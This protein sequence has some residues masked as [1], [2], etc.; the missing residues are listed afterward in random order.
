M[1]TIQK[2]PRFQ[3]FEKQ[4]TEVLLGLLL[5]VMCS[6]GG[7]RLYS[8]AQGMTWQFD[9]YINLRGLT[10]AST[11]PGVLDFVFG[12]TAGPLGRPLSLLTFLANYADWDK[13]PWGVARLNLLFHC[14]NG[15]LAY[16]LARRLL[17]AKG[18]GPTCSTGVA[19]AAACLW[20]LM[21]VNAS[22]ILMPVQRMTQV[23]AF[24]TLFT[25]LGYAA[26]RSRYE[27]SPS[28]K[29]IGGLSA[30]VGLG[31]LLSVLAKENGAIGL[32]L[33]GL[34]EWAVFK[35]TPSN[36]PKYLIWKCWLAASIAAVPVALAYHLISEWQGIQSHF[37][38][39]RGYSQS[40]HIATQ[41]VISWE[42]IRQILVPR[43][44][45][46]GPYQDGHFVYDWGHWQVY[47]AL[48][49]WAA[50][51]TVA[52]AW[53]RCGV[54]RLRRVGRLMIFSGLWFLACHQ[55]ESTFIP[56]ELYFEHRN[57]VAAM[58]AAVLVAYALGSLMMGE[59]QKKAVAL[60]S[61]AAVLLF[62]GFSLQQLTSLWGQPWLASEM[63][64]KNHPN[65]LRATQ[66]L[67]SDN[68]AQGY[69]KAALSISDDYVAANRSAAMEILYFPEHCKDE[70]Q[71]ILRQR[72][73]K[74]MVMISELKQ[75]GAIPWGLAKMGE[76]IRKGNCAGIESDDYIEFLR[77]ILDQPAVKRNGP[78][79]HH[80]NYEMALT[81]L[82]NEDLSEYYRYARNAF[83]DFPSIS[84]AQQIALTLFAHGEFDAALSWVEE[85]LTKAPNMALRQSWQK[86]LASLRDALLQVKKSV[87]NE[88]V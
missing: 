3:K 30:W 70:S 65:S 88:P 24:F 18:E 86:Q 74:L 83:F 8:L 52:I 2:Y 76:A 5:V 40:E 82:E 31:T 38:Y 23:S 39:Y 59:Q 16:L 47:A 1:A 22:S 58:A 25:L 29:G 37:N 7:W 78:V 6:V 63:W 60:C 21:P 69:R 54:D 19:A 9:D 35:R 87:E 44:A 73:E 49:A 45:L 26:I 50:L 32:T 80:S 62:H 15:V 34:V 53:S 84:V 57:Y 46:M 77:K 85:V 43:N 75:P 11:L 17:M 79:R 51:F 66:A 14:L 48:F 81:Q 42:Y 13:N 28:I 56:L 27:G 64:A 12:G 10:N 4:H 20:I 67:I 41:I 36:E 71:E 72:F 55:V 33:V 61:A 68:L